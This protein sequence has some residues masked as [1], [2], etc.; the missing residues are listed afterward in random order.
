MSLGYL[1]QLLRLCFIF[2]RRLEWDL[3][4][5]PTNLIMGLLA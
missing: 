3:K 5:L 4:S 1:T 2:N